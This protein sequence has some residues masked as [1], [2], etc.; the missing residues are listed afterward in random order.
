MT[1]KSSYRKQAINLMLAIVISLVVNFSYLVIMLAGST[2]DQQAAE[3]Q[4]PRTEQ[5]PS[6]VDEQLTTLE[7]SSQDQIITRE[8]EFVRTENNRSRSLISQQQHYLFAL[9]DMLYYVAVAMTMLSLMTYSEPRRTSGYITKLAMC[10]LLLLIFYAIAPQLTWRGEIL[11]TLRTTMW[12]HPM[13]LLKLSATYFVAVLYGKIYDL[14]YKKQEVEVE[15][16]RLK[17][18]N[19]SWQYNILVGQVNPHFLFNSLN[20]LSTL[21]RE[22][23][24][25]DALTYIDQMS[26]TYRYI[27]QEGNGEMTTVAEE[28]HFVE[29]YKYLLEIRYQGKLKIN[30]EVESHYNSYRL[31]P[32]SIQPLIENAVKH[33]TITT[34]KP[35]TVEISANE[36]WIVVSNTI[37]P[38]IEPEKSTGIGLKNL[39][40]RYKLLTNREIEVSNNGEI[41]SVKLPILPPAK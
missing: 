34:A 31:P 27:I 40:H 25:N 21:V 24:N 8:K 5:T 9:L 32:L 23:R 28:M 14:V 6:P 13:T 2:N 33:N 10:T 11:I 26:D 1:R 19:L 35:L 39:S 36:E 17:N 30:A 41:F 20:S 7:A 22:E 3:P 29:A 18:E 38:K 4:R 12:F 16:E 37:A 15:N